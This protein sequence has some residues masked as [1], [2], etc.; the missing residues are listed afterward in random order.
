M[1]PDETIMETGTHARM[2]RRWT[3]HTAAL[4]IVA[5]GA[6]FTGHATWHD[7]G[8]CTYGGASVANGAAVTS[9]VHGVD[10]LCDNGTMVAYVPR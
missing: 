7:P 6:V 5:A 4:V 2:V 3:L 8:N 10:A 9:S 1:E